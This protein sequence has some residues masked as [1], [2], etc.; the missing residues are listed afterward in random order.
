[1]TLTLLLVA[2]PSSAWT[3]P[4]VG[5]QQRRLTSPAPHHHCSNPRHRTSTTGSKSSWTLTGSMTTIIEESNT[6]SVDKVVNSDQIETLVTW[7]VPPVCTAVSFASY[8]SCRQLFHNFIDYASGNTW[9]V[10]DGGKFMAEMV[11]CEKL[12]APAVAVSVACQLTVNH[13]TYSGIFTFHCVLCCLFRSDPFSMV[14][15]HFPSPYYLVRSW[16]PP[17]P[18]ST[19]GKHNWHSQL[20]PRRNK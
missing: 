10:A 8:Q 6:D 14:L 12:R 18:A 9:T 4:L 7:I 3:A 13:I 2:T 1:M 11:R 19:I 15:S 5:P 16:Q 20:W 17:F